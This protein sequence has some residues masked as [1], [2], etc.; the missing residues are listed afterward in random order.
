MLRARVAGT[1]ELGAW[2]GPFVCAAAS[3]SSRSRAARRRRSAPAP[4]GSSRR[5]GCSLRRRSG[6]S[7]RA[8]VTWLDRRSGDRR[9][10]DFASSSFTR[11]SRSNT[12]PTRSI[13]SP[14]GHRARSQAVNPSSRQ[15][16]GA[17]REIR[18]ETF[19]TSTAR[20]D[21][22]RA[23]VPFEPTIVIA[24]PAEGDRACSLAAFH[25]RFGHREYAQCAS[26]WFH[27]TV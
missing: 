23:Q 16:R 11:C 22:E 18:T 14:M 10:A 6:G 2:F 5:P 13:S 7:S 12:A 24:L 8:M 27:P 25:P 17:Q 4:L 9:H 15:T 26:C 19:R 20:R 1:P 21:T 3:A